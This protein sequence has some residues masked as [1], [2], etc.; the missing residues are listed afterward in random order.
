[1]EP[2]I[3][4]GMS[5]QIDDTLKLHNAECR[6]PQALDQPLRWD[7][8]SI[9]DPRKACLQ[10]TQKRCIGTKTGTTPAF[11]FYKEECTMG[12]AMLQVPF[13]KKS[14]FGYKS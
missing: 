1:M 11:P 13:L 9:S 14:H 10:E 12:R 6:T 5:C 4:T 7:D 3:W 2:E 8:T